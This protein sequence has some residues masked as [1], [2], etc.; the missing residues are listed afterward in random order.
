MFRDRARELRT[1]QT[2]TEQ[3]VWFHLRNRRFAGYKFRRQFPIGR[4]IVDFVCLDRR[5]II[6][7]DGG[8]HAERREYDARRTRWLE[9][10]GF[11]V[12]RFW[13]NQVF[14]DW[15]VVEEV[16]CRALEDAPSPPAPLPQGERGERPPPDTP[17]KK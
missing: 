8:Q 4:F 15:D 17:Q 6:E 2:E 11:R 1:H 9:A 10:Q 12:L 7:L 3:R 14:E 5:L 16:I 13:D